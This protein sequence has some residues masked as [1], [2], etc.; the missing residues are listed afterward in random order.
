M[1]KA[2][3]WFTLFMVSL[4][5]VA[6]TASCGSD[7]AT[8]GP[9]AGAGSIIT[10]GNAGASGSGSVGRAGAS[11]GGGAANDTS[12]GSPCT[13]D[14][15]CGE[16]L[17]CAKAN[18]GLF[19]GSGPSFGMCTLACT[20]NGPECGA[21]KAGAECI[22]VGTEDEPANF[23][24]EACELVAPVD[25]DSKCHGRPDFV[26]ADLGQN[27]VLPFC[28]PH[29]RSDAECG[30]GLY[31]DKQSGVLGLCSKTKPPAGD[32]VG[33][34]CTPGAATNPCA[35]YCVRTSADNVTPV[36]GVCIEFCAA[37]SA[38][39]FGSGSDPAPGGF[40]AGQLG[41][42]DLTVLDFGYCL[43]NCSC[44][45]DCKLPGDLCRAWPEADAERARE[46]GAPGVCYPTVAESVELSCGAGG[47]GGDGAG[48]D[49]AGGDGTLPGVGGSSGSN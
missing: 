19:A 11:N 37:G 39:M 22:D 42:V 28:V 20:P 47:A 33:T 31:C 15:Q 10:A 45:S 44:T 40:C 1:V 35:G 25:L 21:L 43:P 2:R 17:V 30:S 13:S 6:A 4:G 9:H 38:C 36:T 32:P 12:L 27:A 23:C 16:G 49:G 5:T 46:L 18:G 41:D 24:L 8:G 34:A 48:G 26:C 14:A 29:C 7:E 3:T